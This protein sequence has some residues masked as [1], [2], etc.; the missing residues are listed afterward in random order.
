MRNGLGV[1]GR[2][3]DRHLTQRRERPSPWHASARRKLSL[4]VGQSLL[5]AGYLRLNQNKPQLG[6]YLGHTRFSQSKRRHR[7]CSMQLMHRLEFAVRLL[8]LRILPVRRT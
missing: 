6:L 3:D 7:R 1:I 4:K 2:T 8:P 5:K